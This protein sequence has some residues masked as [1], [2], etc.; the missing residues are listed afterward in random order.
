MN[1][2]KRV[3]NSSLIGLLLVVAL[4]QVQAV[5]LAQEAPSPQPIVGPRF[6]PPALAH[7]AVLDVEHIYNDLLFPALPLPSVEADINDDGRRQA[8]PGQGVR[9]T[10]H[11]AGQGLTLYAE[12]NVCNSFNDQARWNSHRSPSADVWSDSYAG[13]GAF[14]VDDGGFYRSA[15]V[16]FSLEQT[17][18]PGNKHG[19]GQSAVK[20]AGNQP[21]AAG[22]G[23]PRITVSPGTTVTVSVKYMIFDHDT[24]GQDFDWASLGVKA[25]ATRPGASYVNGYVRGEWAELRNTIV[26]GDSGEIMILLQ[27]QSPAAINSNIYFD[28]VK[29]AVGGE[30]VADCTYAR[31]SQVAP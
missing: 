3:C 11:G 10:E 31:D 30:Y 9:Q 29:L 2:H 17:V 4:L 26:S 28:D 5:A 22:L 15:N 6:S 19:A 7:N 25:D 14:A 21:Y 12:A 1:F 13:W 23:S 8:T 27:G 18:G 16:T 20:V 24:S